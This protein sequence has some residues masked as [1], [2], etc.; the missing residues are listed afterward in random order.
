[1]TEP[2]NNFFVS[3]M[4][5]F[6]PSLF[7]VL[8][9][10][11]PRSSFWFHFGHFL[12]RWK[13]SLVINKR[14]QHVLSFDSIVI[15]ICIPVSIIKLSWFHNRRFAMPSR[16]FYQAH[17][18]L[19]PTTL[20]PCYKLETLLKVICSML[21]FACSQKRFK[22]MMTPTFFCCFWLFNWIKSRFQFWLGHKNWCVNL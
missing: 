14:Q 19:R 18:H 11:L 20:S 6:V 22:H 2:K 3:Q 16:P 13:V 1:M 9:F 12:L 10:C 4:L 15:K 8:S 5:C 7:K 17:V 21:A